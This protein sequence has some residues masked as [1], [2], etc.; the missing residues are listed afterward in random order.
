MRKHICFF[1][2]RDISWLSSRYRVAAYFPFLKNRGFDWEVISVIPKRLDK[3]WGGKQ[4]GSYLWQKVYSFWYSRILRHL[5]LLWIILMA[6][7]F[8]IIFIQKVIVPFWMLLLLRARN[9]N[10]IFDFDDLC[11]YLNNSNRNNNFCLE[12]LKKIIGLWWNKIASPRILS[13]CAYIIVGNK[14]LEAIALSVCD[15][16]ALIPTSVDC[17][18]YSPDKLYNKQKNSFF[19]IG[20]VGSGEVNLRH[21]RLLKAPLERLGEKHDIT[22]KLIGAMGSNKIME[23][24][25][26]SK[27]YKL[28]LID[29]I[30]PEQ[31]PLAIATFSVGVMPLLDDE[32]ARG[33][34]G[35]KAL[36]YMAMKIPAIISPVGFNQE[37]ICD[38]EDGFFANSEDDWVRKIE[39]LIADPSLRDTIG[40]KAREKVETHFSLKR[41]AEKFIKVI[42]FVLKN[43]KQYR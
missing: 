37:L 4:E 8:D 19:V 32:D 31:L 10:I 5:K 21:L 38:G 15:N 43:E 35:F 30:D 22:F 24:F 34:C 33:K 7:K 25:D 13:L 27:H 36:T 2:L 29:F 3:I 23:L 1:T 14:N 20:W 40:R 26:G 16:V 41:N 42:E 17:S 11:F 39:L 28:E 9:K 12:D 6:K 18:L